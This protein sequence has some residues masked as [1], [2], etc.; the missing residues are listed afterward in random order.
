MLYIFQ[1]NKFH[2]LIGNEY[3][4]LTVKWYIQKESIHILLLLWS[5]YVFKKKCSHIL[6]SNVYDVQCNSKRETEKDIIAS[7]HISMCWIQNSHSRIH[8]RCMVSI[9]CLYNKITAHINQ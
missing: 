9:Y 7:V 4:K 6:W 8:I 1:I 5:V 2:V 3:E